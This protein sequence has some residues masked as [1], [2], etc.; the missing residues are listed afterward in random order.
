ME[1]EK[2]K[3][4]L[5][6][7]DEYIDNSDGLYKMWWIMWKRITLKTCLIREEEP[8]I[9]LPPKPKVIVK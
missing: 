4:P 5:I 2:P 3:L 9:T 6:P 8:V 7:I 1:E